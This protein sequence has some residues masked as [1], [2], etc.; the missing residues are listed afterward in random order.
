MLHF[1]K[2]GS[3]SGRH[4]PL[5]TKL[6]LEGTKA[7]VGVH[8]DLRDDVAIFLHFPPNIFRFLALTS[9]DEMLGEYM[10]IIHI[11]IYVLYIYTYIYT[12]NEQMIPVMFLLSCHMCTAFHTC[13]MRVQLQTWKSSA[14]LADWQLV[15]GGLRKR[16]KP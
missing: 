11:Y 4:L 15:V 7:V 5:L 12:V 2:N 14:A 1:F 9:F 10:Y 6:L 16:L 13:S 8:P 3:A